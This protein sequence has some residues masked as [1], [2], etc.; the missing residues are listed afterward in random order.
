MPQVVTSKFG[1]ATRFKKAFKIYTSWCKA[2][3]VKPASPNES[4]NVWLTRPED[5]PDSGVS[6]VQNKRPPSSK[7]TETRLALSK[8]SKEGHSTNHRKSCT[9]VVASRHFYGKAIDVEPV[10]LCVFVLDTPS[11]VYSAR[12]TEYKDTYSSVAKEVTAE[13]VPQRRSSTIITPTP[14]FRRFAHS[15]DLLHLHCL[16]TCNG[17]LMLYIQSFYIT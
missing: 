2:C 8:G 3:S 17:T 1:G 4:D 15:Y 9:Q 14:A 5:T 10:I 6:S 16:F 7:T 12:G 13:L 11:E